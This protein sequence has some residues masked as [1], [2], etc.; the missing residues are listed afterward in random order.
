MTNDALIANE[1]QQCK[2][3]PSQI[4]LEPHTVSEPIGGVKEK[5]VLESGMYP[6]V[7]HATDK[8]SRCQ[9]HQ[10][11][12]SPAAWSN[13]RNRKRPIMFWES[14][15]VPVTHSTSI[16]P[17]ASPVFRIPAELL[18]DEARVACGVEPS[19]GTSFQRAEFWRSPRTPTIQWIAMGI[20]G[21]TG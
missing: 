14:N 6:Q 1:Y 11:A 21:P 16:Q 18:E 20:S 19:R 12:I 13:L 10:G 15:I 8:A 3:S 4:H 9:P 2:E 5:P 17:S 7:L